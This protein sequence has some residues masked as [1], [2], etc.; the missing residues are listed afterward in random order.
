VARSGRSAAAL[1]QIAFGR[2]EPSADEGELRVLL[3]DLGDALRR[4]PSNQRSA[5]MLI[6]VEGKSYDEAANAMGTSIEAVRS[7]LKRGRDRL[8]AALHGSDARPAFAARP[9]SDLRK[10]S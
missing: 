1:E 3:R 9:M 4:L 2:P 7:H 6:G 5:V 8:R 10:C